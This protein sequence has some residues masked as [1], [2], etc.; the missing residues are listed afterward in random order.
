MNT[1]P[2]PTTP[3]YLPAPAEPETVARAR[4][5]HLALLSAHLTTRD[6]WIIAMVHEH[7]VLTSRQIARLAFGNERVARRRLATLTHELRALDRFRPLLQIGA[8]TSQ[9]ITSSA[10]AARPTWWP[11]ST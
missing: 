9:S 5:T 8:G 4:R 3:V 10:R 2:A 6:K 7:K 11:P 1:T